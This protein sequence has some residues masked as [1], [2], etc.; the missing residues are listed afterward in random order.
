MD[1]V[2]FSNKWGVQKEEFVT[3]GT[4]TVLVVQ[5]VLTVA[6]LCIV[7]PKFVLARHSNIRVAQLSIARIV[8]IATLLVGLTYFYPAIFA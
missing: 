2:N 3:Q 4:Q 8:M 7:R 6:I 1:V 5:L